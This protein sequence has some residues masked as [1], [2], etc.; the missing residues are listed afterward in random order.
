[1]SRV[2]QISQNPLKAAHEEEE[3]MLYMEI[4]GVGSN[5]LDDS[6]NEDD[7]DFVRQATKMSMVSLESQDLPTGSALDEKRG[8]G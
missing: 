5:S 7:Q 2:E 8:A 6:L 4:I 3:R 1:M